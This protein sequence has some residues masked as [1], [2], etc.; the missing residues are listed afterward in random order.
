[1]GVNDDSDD[2]DSSI[3][4]Y[5][6]DYDNDSDGDDET[7][8]PINED[9]KQ[10]SKKIALMDKMYADKKC[11][12]D[13]DDEQARTMK[14]YLRK[15]YRQ[16]KFPSDDK[17]EFDEPNFVQSVEYDNNGNKIFESQTVEIVDY[18]LSELGT[19]E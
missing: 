8:Q 3:D 5:P 14:R 18:L 13:Y 17:L 9:E 16:V 19:Y 6:S 4:E 10:L 15:V 1:M 12:M 11:I 7:M 2:D